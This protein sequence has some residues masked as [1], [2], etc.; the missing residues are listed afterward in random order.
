MDSDVFMKKIS[1]V[2]PTYNEELNVKP[3]SE[4]IV[5]ILETKLSK[6]DYEIGL[7]MEAYASYVKKVYEEE[8]LVSG[9]P[10]HKLFFYIR[11][12]GIGNTSK[13]IVKKFLGFNK[14]K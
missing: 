8:P 4:A 6:Y 1:I 2:I 14:K 9:G 10:M 13:R 3:L 5:N 7:L 11:T 12:E